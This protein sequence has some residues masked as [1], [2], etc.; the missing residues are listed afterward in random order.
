LKKIKK[1]DA[2]AYSK[3]EDKEILLEVPKPIKLFPFE[4]FYPLIRNE[5]L[6]GTHH[7]KKRLLKIIHKSPLQN[8]YSFLNAQVSKRNKSNN[9]Q[10]SI[11]YLDERLQ[12]TG[13]NSQTLMCLENI[14]DRNILLSQDP[15]L[16][17]ITEADFNR[18]IRNA[19]FQQISY[20]KTH[21]VWPVLI[22]NNCSP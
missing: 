10:L 12:N 13:L 16:V 6:L 20:S 9:S 14:T 18:I 3:R 19:N 22:M 5:S 4:N 15:C 7:F 11:E 8:S 1:T 21:G 2:H 17:S